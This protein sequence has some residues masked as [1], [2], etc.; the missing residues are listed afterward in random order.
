MGYKLPIEIA[1][2]SIVIARTGTKLLFFEFN[3]KVAC[4][5]KSTEHLIWKKWLLIVE[6]TEFK[7]SLWSF[8]GIGTGKIKCGE[9]K[10][11]DVFFILLILTGSELN[12]N[13][14]FK[15]NK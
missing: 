15:I 7:I 3:E 11:V 14:L 4:S 10:K 6:L 8:F 9:Y 13:R 2:E 5:F 12:Q 1:V